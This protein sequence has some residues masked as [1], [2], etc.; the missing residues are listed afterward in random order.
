MPTSSTWVLIP[1][2]SSQP[3]L[4]LYWFSREG[5]DLSITLARTDDWLTLT[6]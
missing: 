4:K 5:N 2:D 3:L 6:H 1:Y